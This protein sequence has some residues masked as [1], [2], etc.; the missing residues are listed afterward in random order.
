MNS[1]YNADI[2]TRDPAQHIMSC[3]ER[4]TRK[5][6]FREERSAPLDTSLRRNLAGVG[7]A[8][9]CAAARVRAPMV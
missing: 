4:D 9:T 3:R 2:T 7:E 5:M 8:N 6:G 1:C